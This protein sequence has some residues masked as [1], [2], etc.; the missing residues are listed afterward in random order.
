MAAIELLS[1]A[2]SRD[3]LR[4][5]VSCGADSVYFGA[6]R[7]NARMRAKN[8]PESELPSVVSYCHDR[9]VKAYLAL[10]VLVKNDEL[11]DF[12]HLLSRAYSAGIDAVIIQDPSFIVPIKEHYPSLSVHVSTQASV[13][14]PFH[15]RLLE[16]A[17][18]VILPRELTLNQVK[19]FREETGLEVEVFVQGA[20]CFAIGGQCLMSSFLGGRSANRGLCAQPCRKR[21]NGK[22]L[23]STRDLCLAEELP[24]MIDAG[25]S[26]VKIEGRLRSP[27]YVAAATALYRR[28]IDS[29]SDGKFAVDKTSLTQLKLEFS[30]GYTRGLLMRVDDVTTPEAAGKR[31]IPL[32]VLGKGGTITLKTNLQVGDGV[33]VISAGGVHGDIVRMIGYGGRNVRSAGAGK[34]VRLKLN[35]KEGDTIVLSSRLRPEKIERIAAKPKINVSREPVREPGLKFRRE[36]FGDLR[37]LVKVYDPKDVESALEA[38]A[39]NVYYNILS[40]DFPEAKRACAY[41]PRCLTRWI[42]EKALKLVAETRP[43][44]VLCG[45]AGVAS[46]IDG[47]ETYL[48]TSGNVCNDLST[49]FYNSF[50]IIPVISPEL[51]LAGITALADKRFAVYAHGRMPLMSTKYRLDA[52]SLRDEKGYVFPVRSEGECR[53]ILNSVPIGLFGEAAR[54]REAGVGR[55]LLD[56]EDDV[57][58]TVKQYK[59][60][61]AGKKTKKPKGY[62]LGNYR[63]GVL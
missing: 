46:A 48:D 44:S 11:R 20:L 47:I 2:G 58:E 30:R 14:N 33:G 31:G 61:F 13:F 36:A 52:E 55:F 27:G 6:G 50:G 51:S 24:G 18:R 42:A 60:I 49:G 39:D 41:V 56:L 57:C 10:N 38:G 62:T 26:A 53:Q 12:F 28:A 63:K 22:F 43:R 19:D 9:G 29:I 37:L 40:K 4:A 5:A 1:P 34:T 15:K 35:A 21:Y 59:D 8:F 45:D 25:I 23:L 7:F 54:L 17:D 16:G 32:G 3:S